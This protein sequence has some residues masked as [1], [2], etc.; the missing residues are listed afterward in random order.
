MGLLDRLAP[1]KSELDA[2]PQ[3]PPSSSAD[4]PVFATKALMVRVEARY[5][6][7]DRLVDKFDTA[8]D[9]VETTAGVGWVF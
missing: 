2:R 6:Y 3:G 5:R 1:R 4:D 7:L 9:T 8:L